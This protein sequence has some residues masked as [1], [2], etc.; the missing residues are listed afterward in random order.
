MEYSSSLINLDS[1]HSDIEIYNVDSSLGEGSIKRICTAPGIDAVFT[2]IR[3]KSKQQIMSRPDFSGLEIFYCIKGRLEM[4]FENGRR[5]EVG[6]SQMCVFSIDCPVK[7]IRY[8]KE[9]LVGISIFFMQTEK[10]NESLEKYLGENYVDINSFIE[11]VCKK[12]VY[13]VGVPNRYSM[14]IFM[15]MEQC[16]VEQQTEYLRLKALELY[17]ICSRK[18]GLLG[19]RKMRQT[20][21]KDN[22][23]LKD[24]VSLMKKNLEDPLSLNQ[25]AECIEMNPER[26]KKM[27]K[28][29]Y[30]ENI[31]VYYRK[32]RLQHGRML[33]LNTD[34]S[35]TDVAIMSGYTNPSKFSSAFKKEFNYT[36]LSYRKS[37]IS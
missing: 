31:S 13:L 5:L 21:L 14:D 36:P 9:E 34:Y 6:D 20:N 27:F 23:K 15:D 1:A 32:L 12:D 35:V 11:S 7:N 2:N 29:V 25:L 19:D 17:L 16:P 4:E 10:A 22:Y 30:K 37:L 8:L 18:I 3:V 33:L 24:V 28:S 26:L